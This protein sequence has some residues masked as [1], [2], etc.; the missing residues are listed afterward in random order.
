MKRT[1]IAYQRSKNTIWTA[2][3][4]VHERSVNLF[5]LMG[6]WHQIQVETDNFD[7]WGARVP[8]VSYEVNPKEKKEA[9]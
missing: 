8:I 2:M 9:A 1:I 7:E 5:L 3:P 6:T 4:R